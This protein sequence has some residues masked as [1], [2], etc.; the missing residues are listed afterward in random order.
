MLQGLYDWKI[1]KEKLYKIMFKYID[2]PEF[3]SGIIS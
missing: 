3:S 2:S 1:L